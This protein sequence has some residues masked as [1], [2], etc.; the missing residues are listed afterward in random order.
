MRKTRFLSSAAAAIAL[1][2]TALVA[3]SIGAS[4][5]ATASEPGAK[6]TPADSTKQAP[7]DTKATRIK[8]GYV[9]S[10][11]APRGKRYSASVRQHQ[12]NAGKARRR[13]ASR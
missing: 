6:R 3:P 1:S 12:R 5:V 10:W 9:R 4:S 8:T 11:R 7:G 13:A 2:M